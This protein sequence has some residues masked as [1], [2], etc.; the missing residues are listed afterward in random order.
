MASQP[1]PSVR[2]KH[3][4]RITEYLCHNSDFGEF[5]VTDTCP[6]T[7]T[8]AWTTEGV[9]DHRTQYPRSESDYSM[10]TMKFEAGGDNLCRTVAC[11]VR[12]PAW[13]R[14]STS[15]LLPQVVLGFSPWADYRHRP[16]IPLLGG[17]D[18]ESARERADSPD[19]PSWVLSAI[20]CC[21]A[22]LFRKAGELRCPR[23]SW[24]T[25]DRWIQCLV[26]CDIVTKESIQKGCFNSGI[27]CPE[28]SG[29]IAGSRHPGSRGCDWRN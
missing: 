9:D 23:C 20:L 21:G 12:G 10:R 29:S 17:Y 16:S 18:E 13:H 7:L 1:R 25:T 6:R 22:S 27:R 15:P 14:Q 24:R 8:P 28:G 3:N 11:P 4:P 19:E 2:S 5:H 26:G